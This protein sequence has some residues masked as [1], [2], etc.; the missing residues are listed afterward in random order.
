MT[1]LIGSTSFGLL[2][3]YHFV[4]LKYLTKYVAK[5]RGVTIP[6]LVMSS[7]VCREPIVPGP[8]QMNKVR[9]SEINGSSLSD[10]ACVEE[11]PTGT[12]VS[13]PTS[14]PQV[15]VFP[16]FSHPIIFSLEYCDQDKV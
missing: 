3:V 10:S 4:Q 15:S 9:H 1:Y 11:P 13:L 14:F 12:L 6:H 16:L 5:V 8:M 7:S 2:L